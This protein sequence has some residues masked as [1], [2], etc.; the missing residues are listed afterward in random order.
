MSKLETIVGDEQPTFT[1]ADVLRQ[2]VRILESTPF[3]TSARRSSLLRLLVEKALDGV[4]MSEKLIAD[5][6]FGCYVYGAGVVRTT[7]NHMRRSLALYYGAEGRHDSIVISLPPGHGYRCFFNH[8]PDSEIY[9]RLLHQGKILMKRQ[10]PTSLAD[11]RSKFEEASKLS[12]HL[13]YSHVGI[14]ETLF[15]EAI[16]CAGISGDK[17]LVTILNEAEA[18]VGCAPPFW[19][20]FAVRGI[21]LF[22]AGRWKLAKEDFSK[23]LKLDRSS[24][25]AYPG[26]QAYL[27]ASGKE[28]R[29]LRLVKM[30]A[31]RESDDVLAQVMYGVCLYLLRDFQRAEAVL[32]RAAAIDINCWLVHLAM[33]FVHLALG[34][35]LEAIESAIKMEDLT[36]YDVWPGYVCLAHGNLG[37]LSLPNH[38]A[39]F[40]EHY[41]SQI[42]SPDAGQKSIPTIHH[43]Q[44][45]LGCPPAISAKHLKASYSS[46]LLM[47]WFHLW[48]VFDELR[49]YPGVSR[50]LK[51]K[52]PPKE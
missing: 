20:A 6:L 9:R 39:L 25:L 50:M 5:R 4:P 38:R 14:A 41:S 40:H 19:Q 33:S 44:M 46:E 31:T 48:P 32:T 22:A 52:R 49:R 47:P 24:T 10:D 15:L 13:P 11:A 16:H 29:A 51:A 37:L 30:Q 34:R 3:R 7:L 45:L 23:A 27:L 28:E 1:R 43:V 35:H 8:T 2:L 17:Q 21:S 42:H 36:G 26:Y 12:P 18:A